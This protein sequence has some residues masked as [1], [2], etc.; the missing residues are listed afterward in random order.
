MKG[1]TVIKIYFIEA[2]K[3]YI[4]SVHIDCVARG[5]HNPVFCLFILI[6]SSFF[7]KVEETDQFLISGFFFFLLEKWA[8]GETLY[9]HERISIRFET[10]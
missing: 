3:M 10:S 4:C 9:S 7:I 8:N 2:P 1:D 5:V 6:L